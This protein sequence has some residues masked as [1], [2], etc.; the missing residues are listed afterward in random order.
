VSGVGTKAEWT[1]RDMRESDRG[2]VVNLL[3]ELDRFEHAISFDRETGRTTAESYLS[4]VIDTIGSTGGTV[5]VCTIGGR[6]VGILI[7][8][9]EAGDLFIAAELAAHG[10]VRDI[11]V[12]ETER[13]RGIGQALLAEAETRTRVRGLRRLHIGVLEGNRQA[14]QSYLAFGFR[15]YVKEMLKPLD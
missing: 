8:T 10:L 14:E 6:I 9:F 2:S 5:I 11:V 15:P 4:D 13:R 12:S 1:I 3:R 7:L